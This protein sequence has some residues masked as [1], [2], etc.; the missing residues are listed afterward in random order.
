MLLGE[1]GTG[2]QTAGLGEF[3]GQIG[4]TGPGEIERGLQ[5]IAKVIGAPGGVVRQD[6]EEF[7]KDFTVCRVGEALD[8]GA[9]DA[10][11]FRNGELAI[12]LTFAVEDLDLHGVMDSGGRLAEPVDKM[13]AEFRIVAEARFGVLFANGR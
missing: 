10:G 4:E 11:G 12:L 8:V 6:K 1:G 3:A 13:L 5:K 2:E 7:S 9:A